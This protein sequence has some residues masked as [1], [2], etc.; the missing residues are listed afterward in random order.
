MCQ[1]TAYKTL[2]YQCSCCFVIQ[3]A[4]CYT[5]LVYILRI[6]VHLYT[7]TLVQFTEIRN[8]KNPRQE[9]TSLLSPK[10]KQSSDAYKDLNSV[11]VVQGTE[12]VLSLS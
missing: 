10:S 9:S 5:V 2:E 11:V 8:N 1:R 3:K 12:L 7:F 6:K 4:Y